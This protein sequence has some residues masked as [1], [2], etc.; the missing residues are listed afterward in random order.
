MPDTTSMPKLLRVWIAFHDGN[1]HVVI[2][3]H[4]LQ[5]HRIRRLD[6]AEDG[7]EER[8]AHP[9]QDFRALGDVERRLAGEAQ[10]IAGLLLPFDQMRQQVERGLAVADEIVIDEID[11]AA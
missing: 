10:H 9:G 2:L 7:D 6:A 4:R 3:V 1:H 8:L 5:R 11:R